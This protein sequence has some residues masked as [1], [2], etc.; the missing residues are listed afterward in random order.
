MAINES[1]F[2]W[3][4]V[5]II[6]I[7]CFSS[8]FT[9]KPI[10]DGDGLS[11]VEAIK[12]LQGESVPVNFVPNRILTTFLD[13]GSVLLFSKIFG[14]IESGW[15][16]LNILFYFIANIIF[17]KLILLIFKSEKTAFL[18][19]LFLT[20]NYAMISFGL[21]YWMDI[22]GWMFYLLS[23]YFSLKYIQ[24]SDRK[25]LLCSA[26]AAGLGGLFKEYA[27][28]GIIPI[29]VILI[30]ENWPH[31]IVIIKKSFVPALFALV[32]ILIVYIFV[33]E[34]FDYTYATWFSFNTGYA[35][36]YYAYSSKIFSTIIEYIKSFGSLY[37]FL[38]FLVIGGGYY[39][40]RHRKKLV[41]EKRT[42]IFTLSVVASFFPVFAWPAITQRILFITVPAM[43]VIASFL[44]KK[45]EKYWWV[46]L[47]VLVLYIIANFT[48]DAF[49]LPN[50]NLPF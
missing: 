17:Y 11:Y 41:P 12:V 5:V 38:A 25:S 22:G 48:M 9:F 46:F 40:I 21:D 8:I 29:A 45:F 1:K 20:T 27:F 30:Y 44:F 19:S 43:I 7:V 10:I 23:L 34:K 3:I 13:L 37:N 16:I 35:S 31:L 6:S 33:Y 39:F 50:F 32:P 47:P 2:F 36:Q 24:T 14:S 18:A 28:L 26:L 15:L 4:L 49:I 42:K